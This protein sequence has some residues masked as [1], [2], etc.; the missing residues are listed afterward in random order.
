MNWT[1]VTLTGLLCFSSAVAGE[2]AGRRTTDFPYETAW[3]PWM[4]WCGQKSYI[5]RSG[6][7]GFQGLGRQ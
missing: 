5:P 7:E 2:G 1:R 4:W 6:A 3:Y